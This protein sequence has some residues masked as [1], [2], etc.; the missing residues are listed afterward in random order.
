MLYCIIYFIYINKMTNGIKP[1]VEQRYKGET[2]E[3]SPAS[4]H[5]KIKINYRNI[6]NIISL[7]SVPFLAR[8][9]LSVEQYHSEITDTTNGTS[10][11]AVFHN[12]IPTSLSFLNVLL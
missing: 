4:E 5:L 9:T 1:D 11:S 6:F 8:V 10:N 7:K 12:K 2:K 3:T